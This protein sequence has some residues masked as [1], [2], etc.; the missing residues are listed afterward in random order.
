[1]VRMVIVQVWVEH[2]R[3]WGVKPDGYSLH[4]TKEDKS[5]FI[6]EY[7]QRCERASSGDDTP[8]IYSRPLRAYPAE[9]DESTYEKVSNSLNG[10]WG[11]TSAY[12][13]NLL[14]V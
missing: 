9:V 10:I 3:G 6:K 5:A 2:E 13:E 11:Q 8:E 7:I 12:P 1:M 14:E 4:L